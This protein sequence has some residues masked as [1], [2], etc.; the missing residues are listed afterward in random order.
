MGKIVNYLLSIYL[1]LFCIF[2]FIITILFLFQCHRLNLEGNGRNELKRGKIEQNG[3]FVKKLKK[4]RIIR[5]TSLPKP[6]DRIFQRLSTAAP[7]IRKLHPVSVFGSVE[8]EKLG[9]FIFRLPWLYKDVQNSLQR[10]QNLEL[11]RESRRRGEQV[12]IPDFCNFAAVFCIVYQFFLLL[13][14]PSQF[15]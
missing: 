7:T 13:L 11:R 3:Q 6:V 4:I 14:L 1:Y 9:R 10:G 5:L 12:A 2:L 15:L 8:M